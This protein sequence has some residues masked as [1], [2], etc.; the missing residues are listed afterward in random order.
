LVN[1]PK[2]RAGKSVIAGI[3]IPAKWDDNGKVTC[4]TIQTN[5]E[6]V[7]LVEQ[8]KTGE[9]LL[10]LIRQKVEVTGKIRE[11]LDGSTLISVYTY[12]KIEEQFENIRAYT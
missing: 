12:K 1:R 3:I 10:R 2:K 9:E 11:R 4:V 6:K 7:Y 8:T 5:D